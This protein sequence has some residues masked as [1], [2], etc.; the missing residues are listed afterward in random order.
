MGLKYKL[1]FL[2]IGVIIIAISCSDDVSPGPEDNGDLTDIIYDPV[3]YQFVIP[4]NFPRIEQPS[5]NIATTDGINLG[6][7]L[8]YDP[9]LSVDSTIS[10]ASC[11]LPGGSFT[12]NSAVSEGVDGALGKRSSM[13]LLNVAFY[14]RG[15]F[16]DGR[17]ATL[18]SQALVPIEDIHEMAN[19]WNEV[20]ERL[21]VHDDYPSMFRKAFGIENKSQINRQLASKALAQFQRTIVSSGLSKYDRVELGLDVYTDEELLGRDLFFD[22]NP[23]VPDAECNHCHSVPLMTANDYF[24]NGLD[25]VA[26]LN[27]FVDIGLGKV[28]GNISDNGK[29]R[30]PTLRNIA[31]SAPY[32]HDGRFNSMEEVIEHYNSG[33]KSSLN[34][35][36]LIRPLGLTEEYKKA[37]LAF[38]RTMEEPDLTSRKELQNPFE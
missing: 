23:E 3:N 8:F 21:K 26:D 16:W 6:R 32:M 11:H 20:E 33:G 17:E 28:T 4:D 25:E 18:E 10:C 29:F 24:N 13:S 22:D 9:I 15:L 19:T 34:K 35:D 36:P 31:F 14:N 38:I 27:S 7:H 37:L 12:D 1:G 5:D 2:L 30:A